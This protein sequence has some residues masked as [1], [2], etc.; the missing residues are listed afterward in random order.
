MLSRGADVADLQCEMMTIQLDPHR[1]PVMVSSWLHKRHDGIPETPI[2]VAPP[3]GAEGLQKGDAI[4]ALAE[5]ECPQRGVLHQ[6]PRD[7]PAPVSNTSSVQHRKYIP[8][9]AHVR[10][11]VLGRAEHLQPSGRRQVDVL[12]L[13]AQRREQHAVC[14]WSAHH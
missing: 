9:L 8:R 3:H 14:A 12:L 6:R 13:R 11:D 2:R 1:C 7:V 5:G 10:T 4:P